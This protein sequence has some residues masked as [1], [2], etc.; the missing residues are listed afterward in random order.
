MLIIKY[1]RIDF[2]N[3]RIY[4]EDKKQNYA[5]EDLKKAL[6]YFSK[7]YDAS[8]QIDDTIFYWR[9]KEKLRQCKIGRLCNGRVTLIIER[10]ESISPSAYLYI[11]VCLYDAFNGKIGLVYGIGYEFCASGRGTAEYERCGASC[12]GFRGVMAE[13]YRG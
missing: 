1:E 13:V 5:K 6:L 12:G 9:S 4:T 8:V 7:T 10:A 2:F 11:I 3:S